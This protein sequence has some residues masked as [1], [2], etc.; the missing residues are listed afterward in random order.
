MKQSGIIIVFLI[1]FFCSCNSGDNELKF[2]KVKWNQQDDPAFTPPYR[3]K[4]IKDLT[5]NHK[6]Q[7]ISYKELVGLLG[8]P[9]F[10]D[11]NSLFYKI[12]EDYG[13]DIDPIYTK[14]LIF[15]FSKDSIITSYKIAE[16]KKQ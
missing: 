10:K 4:M 15:T 6:L 5:T 9:D 1:I 8:I 12:I 3:K 13:R 7:G 2:D 16:W 14:D 11:S